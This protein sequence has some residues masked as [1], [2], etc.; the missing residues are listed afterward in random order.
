MSSRDKEHPFFRP[1]WRRVAIVAFC[2]AW[3]VW[4]VYNREMFWAVIVAAIAGY[5]AW[6]FL[7][8]YGG[9]ADAP[10]ATKEEKRP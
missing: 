5:A 3:A 4:E 9:E 2:A 1:L 8:N 10:G 7:I 6:T